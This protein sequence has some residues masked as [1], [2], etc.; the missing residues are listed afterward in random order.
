MKNENFFLNQLLRELEYNTPM[1]DEAM[2]NVIV[3]ANFEWN[4]TLGKLI[5]SIDEATS[6]SY[7]QAWITAHGFDF[8]IIT[9]KAKQ[10]AMKALT[11]PYFTIE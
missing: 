6:E 8:D 1:I 7:T 2:V 10:L 5:A 4:E 9:K 3:K 11:D